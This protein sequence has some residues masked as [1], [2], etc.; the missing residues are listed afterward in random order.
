MDQ[1]IQDLTVVVFGNSSAV[2]FGTENILLGPNKPAVDAVDFSLTPTKRSNVSGRNVSIVNVLDLQDS[3]LYLDLDSVNRAI[4]C[5][6][7]EN[8][9]H[10]FVFVLQ[11]RMLTDADKVGLEWLQRMFG[12]SVLPFVMILFTYENDEHDTIIDDLKNN[13]VLEQLLQKCGD[14]YK[15]CSKGMSNQSEIKA[16]LEEIDYILSENKQ[17]CYTADLYHRAANLRE[18]LQSQP[19]AIS[20]SKSQLQEDEQGATASKNTNKKQK[21]SKTSGVLQTLKSFS[22][23]AWARLTRQNQSEENVELTEAQYPVH[24]Q[25]TM[26]Y[27]AKEHFLE[28]KTEKLLTRLQLKLNHLQKLKPADVLQITPQSLRCQEPCTEEELVQTFLQRLLL[29]DYKARHISVKEAGNDQGQ[30]PCNSGNKDGEETLEVFLKKK[31]VSDD[32][33]TH[34]GTIHPMDVQMAVFHCSDSFLKQLLVNKLSQCQYALPLLVP[35]PFTGRNEFHLWTFCQVMKSWKSKDCSGKM[36]SNTKP[37]YK[38]ETPMV[39]FFRIGDIPSSKSQLINTLI[40]GKHNTFFHRHCP[41]SSRDRLLMDGV[42]EISWYLPS[43][44]NT[45]DFSDCVAF[46]NLHGDVATHMKQLEILTEIS[47]VNVVV[48]GDQGDD[49][50]NNDILQKLFKAPKPLICL[51][52]DD[53]S[54]VISSQNMKYKIGLKDRNQ[55]AVSK[56]LQQTIKKCFSKSSSTFSLEKLGTNKEITVDENEM[57]FQKGKQAAKDLMTLLEKKGLSKMKEMYLPCQGKLWR[58]WC[59]KKKELHRLQGP[60]IEMQKSQKQVEMKQIREDQHK[61]GLSN[62]MKKFVD[63]VQF[64][65]ENEKCYFLKWL[66]ILLNNNTSDEL[67]AFRHKYNETWLKVLDLKGQADKSEQTKEAQTELEAISKKLSAAAFGM[68]HILRELGQIYESL[69]AMEVNKYEFLPKLAVEVMLS[70]QPLE[71][72]D[73]DTGHVPMV[74]VSAVLDELI[75]KLENR[76]VFVL[77]ILGIQS[78]GKSTM[79]NALFGLQFAVSAGRC[80]KGAF[81]QLVKVSEEMKKELKFD[82]IFVVD[83]EG[84]RALEFTGMSERELDNGLATFVVGLGNMTLINIFGENPAEMQDILQIVVQAFLRMK[85]VK[86]N[87]SCMFVHQNVGE[88]TA[89][90]KNIEGRKCFQDNL[91]KMTKLAAKEEDCNA[92]CFSDVIAFDVR[93][94]VS[95]FSQLWE[96]SPPM[97]PQNPAYCENILELKRNIISKISK[98]R[99]VTFSEFKENL[100]SLWN[101]L[102]DE[103]FVFSFRN[104]LEIA[105]YRKLEHEYSKWTWSL[106]SAMLSVESKLHN[107]VTNETSV[108]IQ[109]RDIMDCMKDTKMDVEASMKKF[110]NEDLNKEILIQWQERFQRKIEELCEELVEGTKRKLDEVIRL[111]IAREKIDSEKKTYENK[112]FKLSKDLAFSL[113]NKENDEDALV[114]EFEAV[115]SKW[116]PELT[117]DTP[118]IRDIDVWADITKIL[119][120]NFENH[121]VCERQNQGIYKRIDT[122][123]NYSDY[124]ILSNQDDPGQD[125]LQ[126][127]NYHIDEDDHNNVISGE[128]LDLE[129]CQN[130]FTVNDNNALRAFIKSTA[131]DVR[132]EIQKMP[133]AERGYSHVYISEVIASVLKKAKE[134]EHKASKYTFKKEFIVDLCLYVCDFVA[135][136]FAEL[137]KEFKEAYDVRLYLEG[138]RSQYF[139]IFKDY[140]TG[141]TSTAVFGRLIVDTLEPSILQAAYDQTALNL[142]EKM[143]RDLPAFNGN[144]SNLEKH[145]LTSLA[146]EES[147]EQYTE[148]TQ[149]PRTYF[150]NFIKKKINDYIYKE[151]NQGVLKTIKSN[152]DS[153]GKYVIDAVREATEE[154]K[155]SEGDVNMWL[156]CVSRKLQDELR[157]KEMAC[158]EQ[159]EIID[160]DFLQKVVNDGLNKIVLKL[161]NNFQNISDLKWEMFRKKPDE[162][163]IEHLCRCCWAQCPFCNAICTNTLEDHAG[164][165]SV[166]FHRN[167]G[168]NG[169]SFKFKNELGIDFCTTAVSSALLHFQAFGKVFSF[170]DYRKAGGDYARWNIS[171]DNSEMPYWKWYVFRFQEDLEKHYQKKFLGHGQIP[172]EWRNY[173]KKQAI[174]SLKEL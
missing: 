90:E 145:I 99:G 41:G 24:E 65:T 150:T 147:F 108:N 121:L 106:R 56:E 100:S 120:E 89:G 63:T 154:V 26:Y 118:S 157:F 122:L 22:H 103:N 61:L 37:I 75:K 73:G 17:R 141:A 130:T 31:S 21:V 46:C 160:L 4:A 35:N 13:P 40:N 116:V 23:I 64:S 33:T 76:R 50:T 94:D 58:E 81:M 45:D 48:L 62:L 87:P 32:R 105:V 135:E 72:M 77:S 129:I 107:R 10:A 9:F 104:T 148:Y 162:I 159:T 12:E 80:T 110:F 152:I 34:E 85:K 6:L 67:T 57:E 117:Q 39:A 144:R 68:E 134:Y 79:L 139:N 109:Q 172:N 158:L 43:G 20:V 52:S 173:T 74:W 2:D 151:T 59:Q 49:I 112:L 146:E 66:E 140:Y 36:T 138:Q 82:Y 161:S 88:V 92:K 27:A 143:K 42:V 95:Y 174:H 60:N 163:L 111:K 136:Q 101:A 168:T 119:P 54:K 127:T 114:K 171:P 156:H 44:K 93:S 70:G 126:P 165:H 170:K 123:R 1:K 51:L 167:P 25:G 142:S 78:S 128:K 86:L 91:D 125:D 166:R 38:A 115:W 3:E 19:N 47:S 11:L 15:T 7:G 153:K 53:D 8:E 69:M 137:H 5:F 97:A 155:S 84:L 16:I 132:D 14:R 164:D 71:L 131:R 28:E 55:A 149:N 83:T 133:I 124:T 30:N 102:L 169:W 29:G 96:G 98:N 113:K 18:N